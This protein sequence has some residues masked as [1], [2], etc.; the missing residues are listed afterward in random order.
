MVFFLTVDS[1]L[2]VRCF[3]ES[4]YQ[5]LTSNE[6]SV[7]V[8]VPASVVD[9][10]AFKSSNSL[11]TLSWSRNSRKVQLQGGMLDQARDQLQKPVGSLQDTLPHGESDYTT[12]EVWHRRLQCSDAQHQ[13]STLVQ[14][15]GTRFC[16]RHARLMFH[17]LW[18]EAAVG[19]ITS[20]ESILFGAMASVARNS[21]EF[22]G[23]RVRGERSVLRTDKRVLL[24][25]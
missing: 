19:Q 6:S 23:G 25:F 3:L 1:G 9:N 4:P 17:G 15:K 8:K 13:V 22:D 14:T 24:E 20:D 12:L 16:Q 18:F 7:K 2:Q 5:W 11:L 21:C 10:N